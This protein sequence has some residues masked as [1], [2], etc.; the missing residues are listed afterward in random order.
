M[1]YMLKY[2]YNTYKII[3]EISDMMDMYDPKFL[4][5][6][7]NFEVTRFDCIVFNSAHRKK[8]HVICIILYQFSVVFSGSSGFLHQ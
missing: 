6:P 7:V 8:L 3:E 2:V 5:G 4:K 1:V